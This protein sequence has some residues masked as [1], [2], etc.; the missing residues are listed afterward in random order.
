MVTKGDVYKALEDVVDPELMV[1][2][3]DLGLVY[4]VE[5]KDDDSVE[6]EYTLTYPGCPAG[7][8][9]DEDIKHSVKRHAGAKDVVTRVV[10]DPPWRPEFMSDAAKL[11]LG[12]PI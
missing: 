4:K 10:W 11:N 12:Y 9:I 7:V 8:I 1:G 6:V 2:I 3:L 5:V